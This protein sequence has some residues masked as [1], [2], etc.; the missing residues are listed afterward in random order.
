MYFISGFIG[1]LAFPPVY[2]I[3]LLPLSFYYILSKIQSINWKTTTVYSSAFLL[4]QLYWIPFSMLI[5]IKTWWW[6]FPFAVFLLPI[7][8]SIFITIPL[9][10]TKKIFIFFFTSNTQITAIKKFAISLIFSF[11]LVT[12]EYLRATFFPWN[13]FSYTLAFSDTLIQVASILNI[14]V[15]DFFMISFYCCLYVLYNEK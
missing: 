1:G 15:F 4:S 10:I 14:Y 12:F 7:A 2:L 8:F 13:Y 9:L 6:L 5:D 3:F 11:L